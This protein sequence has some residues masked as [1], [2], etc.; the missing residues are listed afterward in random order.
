MK[1][2]FNVY[3]QIALRSLISV[4]LVTQLIS[5]SGKLTD[6]PILISF[7]L[8]YRPCY[9]GIY[10]CYIQPCEARTAEHNEKLHRGNPH[11]NQPC[12]ITLE[13]ASDQTLDPFYML[14]QRDQKRRPM[15]VEEIHFYGILLMKQ[16]NKQTIWTGTC[17]H[18][19]TIR[20]TS[21]RITL[22]PH[23]RS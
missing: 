11:E 10:L 6:W 15:F 20:R 21:T 5:P 22:M 1:Q 13:T 9:W 23:G 16:T 2:S 18:P 8:N 14:V 7:P 12:V 3:F 4:F 17:T 19:G